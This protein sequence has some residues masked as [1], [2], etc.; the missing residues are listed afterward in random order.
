MK[1][2][3]FI[4]CGVQKSGTEFLSYNLSMHPDI[5]MPKREVHYFD[6][7]KISRKIRN[8]FDNYSDYNK[9]F[10]FNCGKK[11]FGEKTPI[12]IFY[13]DCMERIHKYN[14]EIKII[15]I[16]RD[17]LERAF[18]HFNMEVNRLSEKLSFNDAI[19]F[20]NQIIK[21]SD[22]HLRTYSYIERG[23]YFSQLK[24]IYD[25]YNPDN[26][27]IL[28]YDSLFKDVQENFDI[29]FNFLDIPSIT[30]N[31][32]TKR[33]SWDVQT[34]HTKMSLS[35]LAKDI[36]KTKLK[37]EYYNFKDLTKITFKN[38]EKFINL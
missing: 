3:D 37:N 16:F 19:I 7:L 24:K 13:K 27:L 28:N 5:Y 36:I 35:S 6:T 12:Y 1:K 30:I 33:I 23:K 22:Y 17:P 11:I 14:K 18:S 38:F 32:S 2:I 26:I 31:N 29:I 9:S 8:L 25:L 10:D 15:L 34:N 4:I 21:K 20:E